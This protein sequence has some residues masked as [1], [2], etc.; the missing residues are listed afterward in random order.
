MKR[1]PIIFE[2]EG[3][4]SDA[5]LKALGA[6][7]HVRSCRCAGTVTDDDCVAFTVDLSYKA[8]KAATRYFRQLLT[9][10]DREENEG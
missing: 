9:E 10:L 2:A 3:L 8:S 7:I 5:I 6:G 4:L 1:G